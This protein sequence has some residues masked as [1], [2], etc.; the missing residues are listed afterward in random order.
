MV[1]DSDI[2][3]K[4]ALKSAMATAQQYVDAGQVSAS[5]KQDLQTYIAAGQN[6]LDTLSTPQ[7]RVDAQTSKLNELIAQLRPKHRLRLIS[8]HSHKQSPRPNPL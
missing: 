3:N 4:D 6:S 7:T 8:P 1:K 2:V 5:L